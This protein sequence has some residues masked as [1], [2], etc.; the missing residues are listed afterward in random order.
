MIIKLVT[1]VSIQ[2]SSPERL[3]A[4]NLI[5]AFS[6]LVHDIKVKAVQKTLTSYTFNVNNIKL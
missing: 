6:V 1:V 3:K 4:E 5:F 2:M